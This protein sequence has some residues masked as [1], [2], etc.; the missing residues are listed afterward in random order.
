MGLLLITKCSP[1]INTIRGVVELAR[2][3]LC[4][5][6]LSLDIS[7]KCTFMLGGF[8]I[9]NKLE[10]SEEIKTLGP[11]WGPLMGGP[12]CRLSILRKVNVP[13]HYFLFLS[14]N[15][16]RVQCHLSNLRIDNRR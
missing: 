11:M 2:Y 13:C 9:Q 15:F 12:Q 14:V 3:I 5:V 4:K 6:E 1:G 7:M 10:N 8:D 16:K